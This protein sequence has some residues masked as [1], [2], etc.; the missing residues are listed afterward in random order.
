MKAILSFCL[1]LVLVLA[2]APAQ[3][4]RD[5]LVIYDDFKGSKIDPDKWE[6]RRIEAQAVDVTRRV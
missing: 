1:T 2:A 3:A 5:D 6:P 4:H